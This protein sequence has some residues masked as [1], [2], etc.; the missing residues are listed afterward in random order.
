MPSFETRRRV[1]PRREFPEFR[2]A[3]RF[4][5]TDT[6]AAEATAAQ[7]LSANAVETSETTALRAKIDAAAARAL[8]WPEISTQPN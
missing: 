8:A 2:L 3:Q 1:E 7:R 5:A 4:P 6:S